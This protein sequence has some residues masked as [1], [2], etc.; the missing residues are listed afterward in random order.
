MKKVFIRFL[1]TGKIYSYAPVDDNGKNFKLKSNQG[2]LVENEEIIE[3]GIVVAKTKIAENFE[4]EEGRGKILRALKPED[5]QWHCQLKGLARQ[6]IGES[7]E[8]ALRHG[9]DIKILDADLSF[10]QKK[11]TLYFRAK[12]RVDFRLLVLD[13]AKSFDKLIRLQ[14]VGSR[15][16]AKYFGGIGKCGRE[17]CCTKFLNNLENITYELNQAS[18]AGGKCIGCCGKLM[19]CLTFE[20]ENSG[21]SESVQKV[22]IVKAKE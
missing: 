7:Q 1:T 19:C 8:K 18:E 15:D 12:A 22:K 20:A 16:E 5:R 13:L 2:V 6:Y 14:Q 17:L 3:E 4:G 11:L 9:M 21:D 10:D